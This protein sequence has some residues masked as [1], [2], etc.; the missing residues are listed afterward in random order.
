MSLRRGLLVTVVVAAIV[1]V[2]AVGVS[3]GGSQS[4]PANTTFE[5]FNTNDAVS[6]PVPRGGSV[7]PDPSIGTGDVVLIDDSNGNRFSRADIG[8]LT[9]G[10]GRSGARVQFHETGE[11][12]DALETA[13]ALV[14]VDPATAYSESEIDAIDAFVDDGG[15]LL[16]LAEPTRT[17]ISG[18]LFGTRLSEQESRLTGLGSRFDVQFDTRYVYDQTQNDG[19]YK[20]VVAEPSG[21][22]ALSDSDTAVLDADAEISFSVA[23]EVQSTGD[24]D[25]VLVSGETAR[26]AGTDDPRRH[27]LAVR[28]G[29]VLAVGD[30]S[31]ATAGR[32]DVGDNQAFLTG[33]VEFLLSGNGGGS[34]STGDDTTNLTANATATNATATNST[35]NATTSD[36]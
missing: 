10:I 8:P 13:D 15:R 20:Q 12:E 11:F 25:P 32:Y 9:E 28:D 18:G 22:E 2:A 17:S 7:D 36:S 23:S 29:N 5:A 14:V 27:T 21:D 34:D 33:I 24:G 19:T 16:I 4:A 26:T 31:F 6:D 35:A 3:L 30:T 1:V